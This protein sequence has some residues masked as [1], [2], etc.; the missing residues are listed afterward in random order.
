MTEPESRIQIDASGSDIDVARA[1]L[2]VAYEGMGW[3]VEQYD[4]SFAFRYAAAGDRTMT[5]RA[6]RFEGSLEGSMPA[7]DDY[8]VTWLSR[9]SGVFD[10]GGSSLELEVGRPQMWPNDP[11]DF[12]FDR[13]DQ[14][15]IQVRRSAVQEVLVSRGQAGDALRFDHTVAP[16]EDAIRQW[17]S[18]VSLITSTV[19]DRDAS[20]ILQAEMGRIAAISL[21]ELYPLATADLPGELL[22]PRNAHLR[23]AVEYAHEH[24]HLPITTTD[25]AQVA[26]ISLRAL[27]GAF[28]RILDTTPNAYL[29]QLR[30]DRIHDELTRAEPASTTVA[31][32]AKRWGFAHAGRFSAAYAERFGCYPSETL[33]G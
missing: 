19:L 5:F 25:L 14:R 32:V 23:A 2:A 20:P 16:T 24:A 9:G 8:V 30:L 26:N 3:H 29:R 10:L 12:R 13:W 4:D 7:G 11:F 28:V 21:L 22:V 1:T 15:L 6:L 17:R 18:T 31:D 33:A 27:Q